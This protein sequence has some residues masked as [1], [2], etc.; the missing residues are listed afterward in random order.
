MENSFWYDQLEKEGFRKNEYEDGTIKLYYFA[1]RPQG[2][3][4]PEDLSGEKKK[5]TLI[6][7]APIKDVWKVTY[8]KGNLISVTSDI[9]IYETGEDMH[10]QILIEKDKEGGLFDAFRL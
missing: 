10:S 6:V 9:Q 7:V 1:T 4:G 3:F 8:S 5:W 2:L